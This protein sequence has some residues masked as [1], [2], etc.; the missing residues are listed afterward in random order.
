[1]SSQTVGILE[2]VIKARLGSD[3]SLSIRQIHPRSVCEIMESQTLIY[4]FKKHLGQATSM[5]PCIP[6]NNFQY[7]VTRYIRN[8][9]CIVSNDIFYQ[10]KK[11]SCVC[12][13]Q[14]HITLNIFSVLTTMS[15]CEARKGPS[16]LEGQRGQVLRQRTF[17]HDPVYDIH[18]KEHIDDLVHVTIRSDLF[19]NVEGAMVKTKALAKMVIYAGASIDSIRKRPKVPDIPDVFY[20]L[21]EAF[22]YSLREGGETDSGNVI[23]CSCR[24][25]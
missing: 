1:M 14:T 3:V 10:I 7:Y 8:F 16:V 13:L 22:Y 12:K 9:L 18:S 20:D 17:Q 23:A 15:V 21:V 6:I 5:S 19:K 11:L 2:R 25:Y 24:F 4:D